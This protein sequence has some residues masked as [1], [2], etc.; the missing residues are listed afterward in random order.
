MKLWSAIALLEVA[1]A[2]SIPAIRVSGMDGAAVTVETSKAKATVVV[3]YSVL[4]PI[5]NEYNDRMSQLFTAYKNKAVQFVFLNANDN[6][7]AAEVAKH[8]KLAEF[9][10]PVYKDTRNEMADL[11][12]AQ[13]TPE[14][15][16]IDPKGAVRYHGY[17]DDAKNEARVKVQGLRDAI[18]AVMAGKP[19]PRAETKSF[20]CTIKRYRSAS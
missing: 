14:A 16:V 5:S 17:I 12:N 2:A 9:P 15:F 4:C 20:G 10:F 6:E 8:A 18:D 7:S 11:L 1:N 19:V 13:A 3:F